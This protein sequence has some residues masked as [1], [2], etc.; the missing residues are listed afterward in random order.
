MRLIL[1]LLLPLVHVSQF[2]GSWQVS[3]FSFGG[4]DLNLPNKFT[5]GLHHGSCVKFYVYTNDNS[6]TKL[7]SLWSWTKILANKL[8][9]RENTG[10]NGEAPE[11]V[12]SP[13]PSESR[14]V[15]ETP[16][17]YANIIGQRS[18]LSSIFVAVGDFARTNT[19]REQFL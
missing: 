18:I 13:H 3:E 17:L 12:P 6:E 9:W 19:C 15:R 1:F 11:K 8:C 7:N 16:F 5:S 14:K 4:V 2:R 10:L